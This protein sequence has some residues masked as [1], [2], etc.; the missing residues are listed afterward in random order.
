MSI[1][2]LAPTSV[3]V[4]SSVPLATSSPVP[5]APSI[6]LVANAHPMQTQGKSGITKKK[7]LLLTKSVPDYLHTEPP[8]FSVAHTIPQ[9]HEAMSSEFAALTRQST[10]YLVP[11]S[12]AHHIIR[13]HWVFK[14][15]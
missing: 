10:W 6:P 12:P 13:C 15:K 5:V 2:P 7:Q 9:W 11:P 14:L 1:P 8:S 3:T 4:P